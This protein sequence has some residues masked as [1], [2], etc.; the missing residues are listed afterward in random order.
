MKNIL[1]ISLK[2]V[3]VR[4]GLDHNMITAKVYMDEKCVGSLTN[5]GWCDEYYI[6]FKNIAM[7]NEFESRMSRFYKRKKIKSSEY[8]SFIKELLFINQEYM[9]KR[10]NFL[11]CDQLTYLW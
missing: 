11:N 9:S 2:N 4:E 3:S 5:D 10:D 7:E 1:G 8:E 6:E